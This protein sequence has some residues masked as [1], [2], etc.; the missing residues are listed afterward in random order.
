MI[1]KSYFGK[2]GPA[3]SLPEFF[4]VLKNA[5]EDLQG[6]KNTVKFLPTKFTLNERLK[7]WEGI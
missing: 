5:Y 2:L 7:I 1:I 3:G 4:T 6:T